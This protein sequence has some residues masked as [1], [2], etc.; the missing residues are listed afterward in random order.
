VANTVQAKKRVRQNNKR[1]LHTM[2]Q[3]R[4]LRTVCKKVLTAIK[5]NMVDQ[6]KAAYSEAKSMIDRFAGKGLIPKKRAARLKSR[7]NERIKVAAQPGS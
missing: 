4:S 6:A 7:L 3:K 2:A 5:D 1:R